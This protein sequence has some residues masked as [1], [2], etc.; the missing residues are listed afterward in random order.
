[1][2]G[3]IWIDMVNVP[4]VQF[5]HPFIKEFN[6][7][8]FKLTTRKRG[9]TYDLAR[10]FDMD[11]KNIGSDH[12]NK[13][14]KILSIITRTLMLNTAVGKFDHCLSLENA[15]SILLSKIRRKQSILFLDNEM[16]FTGVDSIY[17]KYENRIKLLSSD[18]M[19]PKVTEDIF[20]KFF[21][22]TTIHTYNGFKEDIYLADFQPDQ[23]FLEKVPFKEFVVIRPETL[24]SLYIKHKVGLVPPL[25]KAFSKENVNVIY[26]P[27]EK[28][29]VISN[30]SDN[31][32]IP[33]KVLN[34]L[35]LCFYS[36]AVLTGSGTMAREAALMGNDAISFFP[37]KDLLLVDNAL[38]EQRRMFHS[39]DPKEIVDHVL[40]NFSRKKDDEAKELSK[41]IQKKVFSNVRSVM[42]E[43][44]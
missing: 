30:K 32:H 14:K 16:K 7:F 18:L 2:K 1:M 10:L 5:F 26:L 11:V 38:I 31:I 41:K 4:H 22:K 29:D 15:M 13:V 36:K 24:G 39:R 12:R 44:S 42:E 37:N 40:N 28:E 6:D 33:E 3:T 23:S 34:G 17:Q 8:N 19:I 25:I 9:E 20:S 21:K 35:D 27:R 43:R